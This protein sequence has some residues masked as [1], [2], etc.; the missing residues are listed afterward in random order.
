MQCCGGGV[1]FKLYPKPPYAEPAWPAETICV[2]A[3]PGAIGPGP[4]DHRMVLLNPADEDRVYGLNLGPL[5]TPYLNLPP[6]QGRLNAPILPDA[7]G[8]FDHLA[9][10]TQAF[11]EAHV[12]GTV[13]FVLDIWEGYFGRPIAW[14][15]ARDLGRLEIV[16][17]PAID[18]AYVGYGFMEV[19]AHH[20]KDGSLAPYSLNFDVMA[21]ELGHLIIYATI[22]LPVPVGQPGD[23]FGFHESAAD[24][25]ALIAVLHFDT[26][27][28]RLLEETGG[29][30][31][32]YN[33]LNRFAELSAHEQIR[34]AGNA[35]RLS[36]FAA[37]WDDEHDL[38]QPLTGA[39]FDVLVDIFQELLVERGLIAR[40]VAE[41]SRGV[42][43][44]PDSVDAI[45]PEFD[46]AFAAAPD[47]FREALVEARDYMGLALAMTWQRLT[48]DTLVFAHVADQLLATEA[49]LSGGRYRRAFVESLDWREFGRVA[50]GP[51]LT[52]PDKRS[53]SFS[54]RSFVPTSAV[55]LP[56]M[57]FREQAMM[58]GLT[59]TIRA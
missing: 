10:G 28:A 9:E 13:R 11:E 32:T 22:G 56:P 15:F 57:T 24:M 6:W 27:L 55:A 1:R 17:R 41:L 2:A 5:G 20:A 58:A 3:P 4:C 37:G 8:H 12:F 7:G 31:Y 16:I 30:L 39:L 29:N 51:R 38:S 54:P 14:H 26:L 19:G 46:A 47:G 36:D 49:M 42:R 44:D 43:R 34:L 59:P 53:H 18:N 52:P 48:S 25:T 50:V 21:H 35:R 40:D 23:Y 45:Q 33:E